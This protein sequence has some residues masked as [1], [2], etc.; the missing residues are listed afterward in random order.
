[1]W[2]NANVFMLLS[3]YR[4]VCMVASHTLV[5]FDTLCTSVSAA[6]RIM[7]ILSVHQVL[8]RVPHQRP[9]D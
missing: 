7:M 9:I 6:R 4:S 1:M 5:R 3:V 2:E 8:S